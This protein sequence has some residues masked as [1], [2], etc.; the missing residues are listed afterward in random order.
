MITFEPSL[1][2]AFKKGITTLAKNPDNT[3]DHIITGKGYNSIE[4]YNHVQEQLKKHNLEIDRPLTEEEKQVCR[5]FLETTWTQNEGPLLDHCLKLCQGNQHD[6]REM[7]NAYKNN[8]INRMVEFS[9][10]HMYKVACACTGTQT[11]VMFGKQIG[12]NSKTRIDFGLAG[13]L[14]QGAKTQAGAGLGVNFMPVL[15]ISTG[16]DFDDYLSWNLGAAITPFGPSASASITKYFDQSDTIFQQNLGTI[17]QGGTNYVT[18]GANVT[19]A[20][21]GVFIE[22]GRDMLKEVTLIQ[23]DFTQ[24]LQ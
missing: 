9:G 1:K 15:Q 5:T 14:S 18:L 2:D 11:A 21:P 10:V 16:G 7:C 23:K 4:H 19:M 22:G 24:M 20:G 12:P 8:Y 6:A 3:I 13:G 17:G